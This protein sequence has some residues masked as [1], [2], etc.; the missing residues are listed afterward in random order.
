[1]RVLQVNT[2]HYRRG[3]DCVHALAIADALTA[4][5]H[6]VRFF[7]MQH[8]EN[9]PSPDSERWM[10]YID[11]AELNGTKSV[12]SAVAV[13]RRTLYSREAARRIGEMVEEWRPDVAHLHSIHGHLSLSVLAE[14]NRR[15]IPVVWTLHDFKL[16]CPNTHLM[17]RGA[18][19][20][21]C[22]GGR[23]LQCTINRCKKDSLAASLVAT[24]EAE[25]GRVVD[26][27]RRVDR[28]VAPSRFLMDKFGEFGWDT[29]GFV[30][31]ANFAPADDIPVVRAPVPGRFAY[32]GRLD[33]AKGVGTLIEAIGRT[34]GATLELAGDGPLE[35]DL[36]AL[37]DRV[38]AGRVTFHGRVGPAELAAIRDSSLAVVIPSECKEN[39]P[40]AL[41]EAFNRGCPVVA[42]DV[43]GLPEVVR[44]GENGVLFASGDAAGLSRT[45]RRLVDDDVLVARLGAG[46]RATA[47]GLGVDAYLP[48]LLAVYCSVI[49]GRTTGERA[50]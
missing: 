19:C 6:E 41:T 28:F 23:F 29:A 11:F 1:M 2:Y 25:V 20:E 18:A 33:P 24:L 30:H 46:A 8:P 44:D 9:L 43:G 45:L 12:G 49:D 3:G 34:E 7:G 22:K 36:R 48:E 10:P 42:A 13:L 39:S 38:A 15:G 40:Y 21:R 50:H 37:A 26:P 4:S 32:T 31:M 27:Q 14:L 5:G 16:L 47:A 17:L 35:A